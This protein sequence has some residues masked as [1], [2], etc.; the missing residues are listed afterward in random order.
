MYKASVILTSYNRPELL[1]QA[2]RSVLLQDYPGE[3]ELL[4]VDD[5]SPGDEVSRAIDAL[6]LSPEHLEQPNREVWLLNSNKAERFRRKLVTDYARNINTAI[7]AST[8]DVLFYLTDDD[9]YLPNHVRVL[10]SFLEANPGADFVFGNQ[11][12]E[13]LNEEDG[14]TQTAFY[15]ICH[16]PVLESAA[17]EIDHNQF[18]QRATTLERVGLWPEHVMHYGAAD[19]AYFHAIKD[20]GYVFHNATVPRANGA[21]VITN[22]HRLHATSVQG[23]MLAG[24]EPV[25]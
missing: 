11:V 24:K 14:D 13:R 19:A 20:A 12:V 16:V 6:V 15:R 18:A 9:Y 8:G 22:V 2:A 4:I 21:A 10:C 5:N 7:L 23:L 3:I 17:C 25:W 1:T